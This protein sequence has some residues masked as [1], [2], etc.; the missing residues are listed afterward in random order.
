MKKKEKTV[1]A[2]WHLRVWPIFRQCE[3]NQHELCIQIHI[4]LD[5]CMYR[6]RIIDYVQFG[7][8]AK[9]SINDNTK[10]GF[11]ILQLSR[12]HKKSGKK[13]KQFLLPTLRGVRLTDRDTW[14]WVCVCVS[15]VCVSMCILE[16]ESALLLLLLLT[17]WP[18]TRI[19]LTA[20]DH[21]KWLF[22]KLR[23]FAHERRW[24]ESDMHPLLS[25]PVPCRASPACSIV[26]SPVWLSMVPT[27][28]QTT[29]HSAQL[30]WQWRDYT[31]R[32]LCLAAAVSVE[33][34][35]LLKHQESLV[36]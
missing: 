13:S 17:S 18:H 7:V 32:A 36:C 20:R 24:T 5:I 16:C 26:I 28:R 33:Q 12:V 35:N 29:A 19:R 22:A 27:M 11:N 1:A 2:N 25:F 34:C 21:D 15:G 9:Q 14:V 23:I 6:H 31:A 30:K 4:H 3:I 8:H 10:S